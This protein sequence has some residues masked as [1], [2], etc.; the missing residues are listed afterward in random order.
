MVCRGRGTLSKPTESNEELMRSPAKIA[1]L[2]VLCAAALPAFAQ[3]APNILPQSFA[4]WTANSRQTFHP[5]AQ[6]VM[7]ATGGDQARASVAAA[8]EYGFLAGETVNYTRGGDTLSATLYQMKDP[9]GA[10]GEYSYLRT[11][12][13]APADLTDHSSGKPD[14]A[15]ILDGNLVLDVTGPNARQNA[16]DIKTLLAAVNPK[17]VQGVLPNLPDHLPGA[18]RVDRSDHYILGPET[19]DQFFPGGIG[20]ALGFA[21]SPEVETAH[22]TL[23]GHD[24]TLL[25]ADFPTPQIAKAQ[26]DQLTKKFN[27]NGSQPGASSPA[28]Y[29][30]RS[31][32]LVSIVAGANSSEEAHKLLDQVKAGT[33]LTWSAPTFQFKEPSFA[34]MVVGA[35]VGTGVICL[36][37]IVTSLAFGG[38]RLAVKRM[39]PNS[40]FDRSTQMDIMQLG[41]SSKPIK[42]EDFYAF[43]GKRVNDKSVDKNLPDRTALRIFR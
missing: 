29:A 39:F 25:I 22:F 42:S 8:R 27:I 16:A 21:F 12:D 18:G 41:L 7:N 20:Y 28:L 14:E 13:M 33:V 32:T 30:E 6:P 5:G 35:F 43:D 2:C 4:G 24:A 31:D 36:F 15:L 19:V 37:A 40:V 34:V 26:L 11:P 10:Y 3:K 1:I 38:L 9:S 23:G 17:S